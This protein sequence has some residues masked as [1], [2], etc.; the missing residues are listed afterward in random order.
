MGSRVFLSFLLAVCIVIGTC[1]A[2]QDIET[3]IGGRLQ[4]D[5]R[6]QSYPDDSIFDEKDKFEILDIRRARVDF[7]AK[8][9]A[10]YKLKLSLELSNS[11]ALTD[12]FLEMEPM[13]FPGIRIGQFQAPYG[14]EDYG[15]TKNTTFLE[16][17]SVVRAL[18]SDRNPGIGVF[19][20]LF[21]GI[22]YYETALTTGTGPNV[23]D[24]NNSP[25]WVGRVAV[26]PA[27]VFEDFFQ[28][29]LG[30]S[31]DIGKHTTLSD[32]SIS[33]APESRGDVKYFKATFA[34][35]VEY[36]RNKI[37][38]DATVVLGP[39]L[40]RI[41]YLNASYGFDSSATISGGYVLAS[42][43]LTGETPT[44]KFG[45]N[46]KQQ[47]DSP[48]DE[49]GWGAFELT[50]RYSFFTVDDLFFTADGLYAGWTAVSYD[51]Y[52]DSG[53]ALT[54]GLNWYPTEESKLMMN[55]IASFADQK[56]PSVS[57]DTGDAVLAENA[58]LVRF[59]L[60]F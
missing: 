58:F 24:N 7:K 35:D 51:T 53:S 28:V 23:R 1:A 56:R 26:N 2:A 57:G 37:G 49:A 39:S 12:A 20:E 52:V 17:A 45:V 29:W 32:S 6:T 21:D 25:D 33:I 9:K 19:G 15:S 30:F 59:Q 34:P 60:V 46:D 4:M 10:M 42:A 18:S 41:E 14:N 27:F 50:A 47:V 3:S 55:Y 8:I 31:F 16:K 11:P 40:L 43:F 5:L 13:D 38:V 36:D 22:A 44:L 48:V 54:L